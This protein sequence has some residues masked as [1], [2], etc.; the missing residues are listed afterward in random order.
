MVA[1]GLVRKYGAMPAGS[2]L[3]DDLWWQL[4]RRS[5]DR[6]R[7]SVRTQHWGTLGITYA[8]TVSP[9]DMVGR[10]VSVWSRLY[11]ELRIPFMNVTAVDTPF[12]GEGHLPRDSGAGRDGIYILQWPGRSSPH[13]GSDRHQSRAGGRL[14]EAHGTGMLPCPLSPDAN[15]QVLPCPVPQDGRANPAGVDGVWTA[16]RLDTRRP[17]GTTPAPSRRGDALRDLTAIDRRYHPLESPR[18]VSASLAA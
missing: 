9:D 2:L 6:R 3:F 17:W 7:L 5:V 11:R 16:C 13:P 1:A 4:R 18:P 14:T 15:G 10:G 12:P 8:S